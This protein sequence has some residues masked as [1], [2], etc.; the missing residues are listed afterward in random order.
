M[1]SPSIVLLFAAACTVVAIPTAP[2]DAS[3]VLVIESVVAGGGSGSHPAAEASRAERQAEIEVALGAIRLG[4]LKARA[5][6]AEGRVHDARIVAEASLAAARALPASVDREVLVAPLQ[7][8]IDATDRAAQTPSDGSTPV[9][10]VADDGQDAVASGDTQDPDQPRTPPDRSGTL[11]PPRASPRDVPPRPGVTHRHHPPDRRDRFNRVV[12]RSP[13]RLD[14]DH[15]RSLHDVLMRFGEAPTISRS[16]LVYPDDWAERSARRAAYRDGVIYRGPEFR[17]E[18]GQLKQTVIYD[19]SD[20]VM[21]IP[22]F[23]DAPQLDLTMQLQSQADR[24]ALRET[25]RIFTGYASDLEQGIP[26]LR[27]FGGLEESHLPAP[28]GAEE[29]DNLMRLIGQVLDAK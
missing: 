1:Q 24:A 29:R 10:V 19:I 5:R 25:S 20:L 22:S 28:D 23:L 26:L 18:D 2:A 27:Y 11:D 15:D 12:F 4:L 17:D 21:P 14:A 3:E 13:P 6:L 9:A 7:D 16:V 8:V